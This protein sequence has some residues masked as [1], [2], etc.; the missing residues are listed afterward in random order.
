MLAR[1]PT[2]GPDVPLNIPAAALYTDKAKLIE[3][4]Q[5]A[6][7]TYIHLTDNPRLKL[8]KQSAEFIGHAIGKHIDGLTDSLLR[9]N[10]NTFLLEAQSLD[11]NEEGS[12][13][14]YLTLTAAH[15]HYLE[16]KHIETFRRRPAVF[17]LIRN[18]LMLLLDYESKPT[19]VITMPSMSDHMDHLRDYVDFEGEDPEWVEKQKAS[20]AQFD[21]QLKLY[22][23]IIPQTKLPKDLLKTARKQLHTLRRRLSAKE[24]LWA[25]LVIKTVEEG[26]AIDKTKLYAKHHYLYEEAVYF[27]NAFVTYWDADNNMVLDW[28]QDLS[29]SVGNYGDPVE[30]FP[31]GSAED[32]TRVK[33]Y[34][35]YLYNLRDT[36]S[37]FDTL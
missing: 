7:R 13:S 27:D 33:A 9:P 19:P 1:I 12:V 8:K 35:E 29:E 10:D 23:E 26:R 2:L 28:H 17:R 14:M 24:V 18:L 20:I 30:F 16:V 11:D 5:G 4:V 6:A 21:H 37:L 31:V 22:S 25:E 34:I 3:A 36:F 32:V 15:Y